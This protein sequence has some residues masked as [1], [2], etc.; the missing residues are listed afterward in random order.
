M[1]A[2]KAKGKGSHL[3]GWSLRKRL[4]FTIGLV[5]L[6]RLGTA[7]PLPYVDSA[8]LKAMWEASGIN[9]LVQAMNM[10]GSSFNNLS[11]FSL[12]IMPYITASIIMQLMKMISPKIDEMYKNN[13]DQKKITE[14]T[15][16]LT[17]A[18]ATIQAVSL[19]I[20]APALFNGHVFTVDTTMAKV[21]TIF[22]LVVGAMVVM[23]MGEEITQRGV[24]NGASLIIF[25]SI[26]AG[27]PSLFNQSLMAKNNNYLFVVL[28]VLFFAVILAGVV[29]VEKSEYRAPVTYMKS[30]FNVTTKGTFLPIKVAIAGVLP[31]IFAGSFMMLPQLLSNF[32]PKVAWLSTT[33]N[34]LQNNE[35][36]HYGVYILLT[37]GFTFFSIPLVFDVKKLANDLNTQGGFIPGKRPGPETLDYL[38]MI[39]ARMAILCAVYLSLL[40]LATALVL[41]QL[42][43]Q[44]MSFS[45][46][47]LIILSTVAITFVTTV[48]AE[49]RQASPKGVFS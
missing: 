13:A 10:L 40:V 32:F 36:G 45:A 16:Y 30:N 19:T 18:L 48:E 9:S 42:G 6:Y 21:V 1:F 15:R 23:R 11:L 31:V 4:L 7:V 12:G 47:S 2:S 44:G 41:P 43:V 34:F 5:I 3:E 17:V 28:M 29:F 38:E 26:A 27:I 39:A 49:Q 22:S 14:W 20:G 33:M 46:T 8:G 24:G 37:V 35:W 25:S